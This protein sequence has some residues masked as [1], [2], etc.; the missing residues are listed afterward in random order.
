MIERSGEEGETSEICHFQFRPEMK[1][2]KKCEQLNL[3]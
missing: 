3:Q 2:N 1:D